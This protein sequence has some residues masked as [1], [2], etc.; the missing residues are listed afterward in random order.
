M[1]IVS[2]RAIALVLVVGLTVLAAIDLSLALERAIR[3]TFVD[4]SPVPA[5]PAYDPPR[6][7]GRLVPEDRGAAAAARR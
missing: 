2:A 7:R 5:A 1:T 3:A 6:A 4:T